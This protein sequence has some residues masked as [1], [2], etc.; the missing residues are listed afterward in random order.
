CA[1]PICH[2]VLAALPTLTRVS[3][4]ALLTGSMTEAAGQPAERTGFTTAA[5]VAGLG[6]A[7]LFHK[8]D[9]EEARGVEALPP[10]VSEAI[11][12]TTGRRLVGCVLNTD[13]KS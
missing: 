6:A 13:R 3:R 4:T 5:D 2:A 8:A 10:T 1:L 9:L 7:A 12:D 11:A